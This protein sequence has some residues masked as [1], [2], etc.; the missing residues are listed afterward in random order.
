ML[1]LYDS[2]STIRGKFST[3]SNI[4]PSLFLSLYSVISVP[5]APV[6]VSNAVSSSTPLYR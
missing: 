6:L 1:F 5:I 3:L 4:Y 2:L